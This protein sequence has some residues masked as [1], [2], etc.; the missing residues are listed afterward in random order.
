[1]IINKDKITSKTFIDQVFFFDTIDS[2]NTYLKELSK[3][4]F[5][6]NTLVV[7]KNQSKGRGR[8]SKSFYSPEN[9]LYF[10]F[11]FKPKVTIEEIQM[12]TIIAAL[13]VSKSINKLY[14][15]DSKIKWLNDIYIEDKKICGILC[16][17][18]IKNSAQYEF[19][20]VGIGINISEALVIPNDIKDI[21]GAI[22]NY[23]S[24]EVDVNDLIINIINEFSTYKKTEKQSLINEYKSKC[25]SLNK[26]VKYNNESYVAYDIN[27]YGH[28]L[29]TN[30]H[31]K[32][33][34]NAGEVSLVYED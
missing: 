28:L 17:T 2:T 22:S 14:N 24:T 13:A 31:S 10:S 27:S 18:V 1:M 9:G 19:V 4:D 6:N 23:S 20:V 16:D 5:K 30:G 15:V 7:A 8:L 21:Y 34:V 12:L 11:V 25:L 26:K 29:L 32:I 33:S 3:K